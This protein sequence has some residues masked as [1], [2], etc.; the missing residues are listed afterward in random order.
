MDTKSRLLAA[1]KT[2]GFVLLALVPPVL[3]F[4]LNTLMLQL[5]PVF[6]MMGFDPITAID[7]QMLTFSSLFAVLCGLWYALAFLRKRRKASVQGN[8]Q[9]PAAPAEADRSKRLRRWGLCLLASLL[10]AVGMQYVAY[11]IEQAIW[12]LFPSVRAFQA[13]LSGGGGGNIRLLP[14]LYMVILGP[15][16][17]ELA[18]RGISQGY[19]GRV[20]PFW[21]ANILQALLF[22]L[23][24]ANLVQGAYCFLLG[25][26]QGCFCRWGGGVRYAIPM[27]ILFNGVSYLI[28]GWIESTLALNAPLFCLLGFVAVGVSVRLFRWDTV[29]KTAP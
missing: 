10:A 13:M 16:G 26:L 27:H 29:A 17:E 9:T 15:I 19:A 7:L 11:V 3:S 14:I 8:S 6:L 4:G 12:A 2:A 21:W 18:F 20:M 5:M 24:H 22:G 1:A 28:M 23:L 25:L